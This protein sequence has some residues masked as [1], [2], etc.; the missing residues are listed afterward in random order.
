[1]RKSSTGCGK[2]GST[3]QTR[4][5]TAALE[6]TPER[7]APTSG[8]ASVYARRSQP[9]NGSSGAFTAKAARNPRKIQSLE[10]VPM[11]ASRKVPCEMPNAMI[12]ASIRSEP[13]IV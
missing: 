5:K 3:I 4:P 1:M 10:L 9:W 6:T 13:T 11:S 2:C 12:D 8:G 7:I